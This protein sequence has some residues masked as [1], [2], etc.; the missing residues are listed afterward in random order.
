[1]RTRNPQRLL[2]YALI[3]IGGIMLVSRIGGADWLWLA[4]ISA[5]FLFG[6]GV[7]EK[8]QLAGRR[9]R[10]DGH[11]RRD[12]DRYRQRDAFKPRRRIFGD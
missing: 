1:M 12:A 4:L 10:L 5:L 9:E 8:L 3:V 11:C 2:A 6:Y 7:A